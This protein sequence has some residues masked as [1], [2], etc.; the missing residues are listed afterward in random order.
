MNLRDLK[1]DDH[2]ANRG[3]FRGRCAVERSLV[4][5]GA[6]RSIVVDKNG[7][8]LA[9]NKTAA[10]AQNAG[11]DDEVILVPTDGTKLV[12]VQRTDLDANDPKAKKLAVADNRAAEL[13][14]EWDQ[15]VMK[16][17][18]SITELDLKPYFSPD[19]LK[20][21]TDGPITAEKKDKQMNMNLSYAIIVDVDNEQEQAA[22]LKRFEEEG[23]KCRLLIS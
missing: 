11:I 12:V 9:G 1:Q 8:I 23:L 7:V 5:V 2:N 13:G 14:L 10:A 15:E 16:E 6:G 4:D 19:E 20:E 17:L 21:I 3:T 18:S 22:L